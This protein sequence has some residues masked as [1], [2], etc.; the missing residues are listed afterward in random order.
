MEHK[1]NY[2]IK[3]VSRLLNIP[4]ATIRYWDSQGLISPER[5]CQNDY[6]EFPL[7]VAMELSNISFF[8]NIDIP[9]K[10]LKRMLHSDISV[11]EELLADAQERILKQQK[12]LQQQEEHIKRQKQ[13]LT[14]IKRLKAGAMDFSRPFFGKAVEFSYG[15]EEHWQ[16]II[17]EPGAFVLLF[18]EA[19]N[20]R[21][22]YGI[23]YRAEEEPA[24]NESVVWEEKGKQYLEGLLLTNMDNEGK[25]NLALLRQQIERKGTGTGT[26]IAQY[27][28]SGLRGE[29]DIMDYYKMWMEV[30][31]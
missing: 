6:R 23:G 31:I 11:Q 25:N 2:S 30:K 22:R 21:Y 20:T 9:V 26:V 13:A 10:E 19:D 5:N 28:T 17:E 3:E 4:K 7:T 12:L 24:E 27:L 29:E 1:K 14:E 8:R 18:D 15:R 16:K